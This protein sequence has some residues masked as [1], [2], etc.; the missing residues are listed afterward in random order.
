MP[1]VRQTTVFVDDFASHSSPILST[2]LSEVFMR[3]RRYPYF[4]RRF[5]VFFSNHC[6]C[7]VVCSTV[8]CLQGAKPLFSSTMMPPPRPPSAQ[9]TVF[10]DDFADLFIL[11]RPD[12]CFYR[13]FGASNAQNHCFRRRCLSLFIYPPPSHASFRVWQ[14]FCFSH[15]GKHCKTPARIKS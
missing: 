10:V 14:R 6:F 4:Y 1:P 7:R 15:V 3:G 2:R 12:H 13:R 8:S 5:C 11:L 9:T